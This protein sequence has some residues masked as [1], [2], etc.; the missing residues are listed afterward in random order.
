LS[1]L[2]YYLGLISAAAWARRLAWLHHCLVNKWFF[3]ELY[4]WT[5][6]RPLLRLNAFLARFDL[7]WI[8]GLV[9]GTAEFTIRLC[10]VTGWI[11]NRL[12]DGMVN[13]TANTLLSSGKALT[14]LQ[15]GLLRQYLAFAVV[16][17]VMLAVALSLYW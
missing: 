17:M 5:I 12:V 14:R 11:D 3:D 10:L 7:E 8:D 1:L 13:E 2:T 16:G 9:N 15:S 6:V 4:E